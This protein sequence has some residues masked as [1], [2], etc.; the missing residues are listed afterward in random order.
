MKV[1]KCVAREL[2]YIFETFLLAKIFL[3]AVFIVCTN[4]SIL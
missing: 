2:I 3:N 1:E 4:F